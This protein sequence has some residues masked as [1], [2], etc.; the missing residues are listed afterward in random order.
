MTSFALAHIRVQVE[1]RVPGA[2]K[3]S[4]APS[5]EMLPSRVEV[6]DQFIGGIPRRA[7]TEMVSA[8]GVSAGRT[9]LLLALLA[10]A[11]ARGEFCALVDAG[12]SFDPV[13]AEGAGVVLQRLLWVR[14]AGQGL[15]TMEQSFKTVDILA[16]NGGFGLIAADLSWL[17]ESLVRKVPLIT[18]FRLARVLEKA[19]TALLFLM[20]CAAAQ[21]C[22]G[23]SLHL[24]GEEQCFRGAEKVSHARLLAQLRCQVTIDRARGRKPVQAAP[25]SLVA[26]PR[27]A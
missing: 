4:R 11:T 3:P 1:S 18:W 13:S 22:A 6:V 23:L 2:L 7:L 25:S 9:A 26:W 17:P 15:K 8:P 19:P 16:Q 10:E 5:L 24:A 14:C 12:D 20:S 21:S 27:W